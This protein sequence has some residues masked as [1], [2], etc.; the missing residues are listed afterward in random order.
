MQCLIKLSGIACSN[1]ESFD[2]CPL[3][4]WNMRD[5]TIAF[6]DFATK[7]FRA[8]IKE[9]EKTVKHTSSLRLFGRLDISVMESAGQYC[10]FASGLER[11]F[12]TEICLSCTPHSST[13]AITMAVVLGGY[14]YWETD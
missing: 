6:H 2:E 12:Q 11:S 5:G 7:T 14:C 3:N 13:F 4:Y 1:T 8:L 9:E 10:Y